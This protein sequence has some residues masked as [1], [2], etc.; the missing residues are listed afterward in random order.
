[1][2]SS[3]SSPDGLLLFLM[4]ALLAY[5]L[6]ANLRV[7][8]KLSDAE[9]RIDDLTSREVEQL[10]QHERRLHGGQDVTN[11][12]FQMTSADFR[13][14]PNGLLFHLFPLWPPPHPPP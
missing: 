8:N 4:V 12:G 6:L 14:T 10:I 9:K 1:M 11:A 7:G 5:V 3:M 13:R 2:I